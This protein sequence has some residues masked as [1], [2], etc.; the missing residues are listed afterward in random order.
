MSTT[1]REHV[2][3]IGSANRGATIWNSRRGGADRTLARM[4]AAQLISFARGAPS[5]DIID[6]AGLKAA[7]AAGV[8]RRS[9]RRSRATDRPPGYGP[10]REW[11]AARHGVDVGPGADHQRLAAGRRV[12]L[13]V[14][15]STR[16]TTSSSRSRP[17]TA[18]CSTSQP[19]REDP[20]GLARQG[21]HRRR[22]AAPAA[23]VRRAARS[24][25]TS[26]RTSRTRP[27]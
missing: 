20:P 11:I 9:R 1:D 18:R 15:W 10:L 13:R 23:R 22:R 14:T 8:R 4:T 27:A 6:V 7:A 3:E 25:R 12:H 5:L 19:G 16:A 24:S 17:T 26:S 2:Y 21:R